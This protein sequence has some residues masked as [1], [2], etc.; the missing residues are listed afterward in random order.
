MKFA[1]TTD[2][3]LVYKPRWDIV[4]PCMLSLLP[5]SVIFFF[6]FSSFFTQAVRDGVSKAQQEVNAASSEKAKA[7]AQIALECYEALQKALEAN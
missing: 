5:G 4:F 6:F 7:E 3:F 2:L 1:D